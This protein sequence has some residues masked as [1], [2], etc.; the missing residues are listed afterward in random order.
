[1]GVYSALRDASGVTVDPS[2]SDDA[3]LAGEYDDIPWTI[4]AGAKLLLDVGPTQEVVTVEPAPFAV[5]RATAT[6]SF[7]V[8]VSRPHADGFLIANTLLGNPGPQPRF[9]PRGPAFAAIVRYLSV[10]Q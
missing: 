4:R 5:D 3:T 7:R 10:I 8:V 9:D 6:G 1:S 2:R